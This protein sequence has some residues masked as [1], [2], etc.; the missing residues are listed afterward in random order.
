MPVKLCSTRGCRA[1]ATYRGRCR[2]HARQRNRS[3][4]QNRSIYNSRRWAILRR[5]VLFE[6]PLC[7]C[8]EIATDVDH[9]RAIEDGG[10]PWARSNL[11]ARCHS[12][13]SRKT[14]REMRDR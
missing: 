1:V 8:G 2:E 6:Q 11:K 4:H 14:A 12:C 3:T 7:D 5:R 9:D 10:D 13:H